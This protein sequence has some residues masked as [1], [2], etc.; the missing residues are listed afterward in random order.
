MKQ[1]KDKTKMVC[2]DILVQTSLTFTPHTSI[3]RNW[4]RL[5]EKLEYGTSRESEIIETNQLIENLIMFNIDKAVRTIEHY[6]SNIL[7][8]YGKTPKANHAEKKS[9]K[10]AIA[11]CLNPETERA[12]DECKYKSAQTDTINFDHS[13]TNYD[14]GDDKA[15]RFSDEGNAIVEFSCQSH[16][17]VNAATQNDRFP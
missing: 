2:Q 12:N 4:P 3:S 10:K 14:Y 15:I 13:G 11:E 7:Q 5:N 6:L 17:K 16:E 8:N 9:P 1:S